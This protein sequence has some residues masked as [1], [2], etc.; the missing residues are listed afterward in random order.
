MI[1][2][3]LDTNIVV[4]ATIA[5]AGSPARILALGR[6]GQFEIVSSSA[7]LTET[8]RTLQR[9]R[10]R[11]KYQITA[12]QIEGMRILLEEEASLTPITRQVQGIASHSED[13]Q[14]LATA[15]SAGADYLVTGDDKLQKL[16]TYQGVTIVSPREFLTILESQPET[17]SP[18][19]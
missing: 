14:I 6:S 18:V 12:V 9:D 3:V 10:I 16:G 4:S 17:E 13:D 2:A 11:R 1:R 7:I 8:L 19:T 5:P 15:I